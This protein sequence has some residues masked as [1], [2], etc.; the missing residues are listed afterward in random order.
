MSRCLLHKGQLQAFVEWLDKKRIQHRTGRGE[1]QI[2]QVELEGNQWGVVYDRLD[3]PEH[4]TVTKPM[5]VLV[6]RFVQARKDKS[7]AIVRTA[8]Q[9]ERINEPPPRKRPAG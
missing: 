4:Y 6:R 3:A 9:D 5:E 2:L 7:R 1:F 8:A